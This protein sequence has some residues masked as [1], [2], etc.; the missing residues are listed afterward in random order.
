MF[1]MLYTPLDGAERTALV[2][3]AEKERHDPRQQAV[4][5]IRRPLE[6]RGLDLPS[7]IGKLMEGQ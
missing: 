3:L 5:I 6:E 7:S 2:G 1:R 4:I